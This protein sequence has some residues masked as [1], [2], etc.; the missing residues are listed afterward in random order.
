MVD[1]T[2][3]TDLSTL[4]SRLRLTGIETGSDAEAILDDA[5]REVRAGFIRR[6][7]IARVN[8]LIAIV[9][10]SDGIPDN[11]DDTLRVLAEITEIKWVK[12]LLMRTLTQFSLDGSGSVLQAWHD[13]APFRFMGEFDKSKEI[14]RLQD[15]IEENLQLL[16]GTDNIASETTGHISIL[17]ADIAPPRPGGTIFTFTE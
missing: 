2:F 11:N 5:I 8:T 13:E 4:K 10:D 6:L 7:G 16:E 17:E 3:V 14:R 15:E 12:S 9:L 1:P